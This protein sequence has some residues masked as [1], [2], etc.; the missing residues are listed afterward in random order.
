MEKDYHQL[1]LEDDQA[2]PDESALSYAVRMYGLRRGHPIRPSSDVIDA[3]MR[4]GIEQMK[5]EAQA[6]IDLLRQHGREDVVF[7][8]LIRSGEDW[9]PSRSDPQS[10]PPETDA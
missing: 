4:A 5:R 7:R 8:G 10:S 9:P 3:C 6:N 1:Q 2:H